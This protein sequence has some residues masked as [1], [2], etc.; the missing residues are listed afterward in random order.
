MKDIV[1]MLITTNVSF[2]N[3]QDKVQFPEIM[4][5]LENQIVK[6]IDEKFKDKLIVN[7]GTGEWI[8]GIR[9]NNGNIIEYLDIDIK[10]NIRSPR[11]Y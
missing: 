3:I 4:C 11:L 2:K 8:R 9:M 6:L 5:E 10:E 7:G 1:G